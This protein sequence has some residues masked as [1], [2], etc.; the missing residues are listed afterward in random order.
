MLRIAVH[1]KVGNWEFSRL[2]P[3]FQQ[4]PRRCARRLDRR[5]GARY[6]RDVQLREHLQIT[7]TALRNW[8]KAQTYDAVVVGCLWLVGLLIVGVPAAPLWA[9]LG[10]LF[11]FVPYVGTLLALIGPAATA[12]ISGGVEALL[13]V[14]ILYA[15]IVALDGLLL[16]PYL[17]RRT[18]RVPIWV[19]ML[20]PLVLG[21][22][23]NIWGV[24]LSVP[25]LA[26]IYAYRSRS[27]RSLSP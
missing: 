21:M 8:L 1:V 13:H 19:S 10:A 4:V 18:T 6:S 2:L 9:L 5:T 27:Q 24:L 23:L 7:G 12:G 3:D 14:A 16:Q 15:V 20:T 22:F 11:Q 26:V 17:M 25:L